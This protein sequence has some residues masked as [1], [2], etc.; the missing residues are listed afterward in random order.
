MKKTLLTSIVVLM[1]TAFTAN[2]T[3]LEGKVF[4]SIGNDGITITFSKNE[5]TLDTKCHD[6]VGNYSIEE[7]GDGSLKVNFAL[8]NYI[9]VLKESEC[10]QSPAEKSMAQTA[11]HALVW[12]DSMKFELDKDLHAKVNMYGETGAII[13]YNVK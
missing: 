8:Q 5:A 10:V 2:A 3:S 11:L 9:N 13:S 7:K 12:N 6:A 4:E 1:S